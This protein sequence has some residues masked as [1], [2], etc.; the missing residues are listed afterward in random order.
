[1][2]I[3]GLAILFGTALLGG[4]MKSI[5]TF[6]RMLRRRR[7]MPRAAVPSVRARFVPVARELPMPALGPDEDEL[8][9][10]GAG[11]V[12]LNVSVHDREL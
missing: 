6:C 3:N 7:P 5:S 2:S 11:G 4:V 1:L 12:V 9:V 10:L 8:L